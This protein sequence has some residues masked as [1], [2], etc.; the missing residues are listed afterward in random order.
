MD[1]EER[2]AQAFLREKIYNDVLALEDA[3]GQHNWSRR[4]TQ[5]DAGAI[6]AI[7]KK[8]TV[9]GNRLYLARNCIQG[10]LA[11]WEEYGRGATNQIAEMEALTSGLVPCHNHSFQL[12]YNEKRPCPVCA[13]QRSVLVAKSHRADL[14]YAVT[15]LLEQR[16]DD[17]DPDWEGAWQ[18]VEE[19]MGSLPNGWA[20]SMVTR[21][22]DR[23]AG[24]VRELLDALA[25][26]FGSDDTASWPSVLQDAGDDAIQVL[27]GVR[28]AL[29]RIRQQFCDLA[30][31]Q[32][33][34]VSSAA[35]GALGYEK[36]ELQVMDDGRMVNARLV[37]AETVGV[38]GDFSFYE[39][40]EFVEVER[41]PELEVDDE[42]N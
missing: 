26:E 11:K 41:F 3:V 37:R 17:E 39:G 9:I 31:G 35:F 34:Y 19:A 1:Q 7:R 29:C 14:A 18:W 15:Y 27:D 33:F 38:L 40:D 13:L 4:Q 6:S 25:S 12:L 16:D 2:E 30:V 42:E 5:G 10:L 36:I 8:L 23:L 20:E 21:Q 24:A 22:R 32:T 28:G